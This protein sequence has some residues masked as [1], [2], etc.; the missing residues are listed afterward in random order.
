MAEVEVGGITFKGGRIILLMTVLST[1]GGGAWGAFEFYNDYR[2]MK[3]Q[4][5]SYIAPDMSGIETELAVQ[6]EMMSSIAVTV[7]A[8]GENIEK[9]EDELNK[10][11]NNVE[12]LARDTDDRTAETQ[13]ELRDDVYSLE[14]KVNERL[15]VI[16]E[17]I[18]ET[19]KDLDEKIQLILENPLNDV[20]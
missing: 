11:I 4:I 6:R 7:D 8:Q 20:E 17:D 12:E 5:Q 13:R 18:R 2:E 3:E 16:D 9:M 15:R 10:D 14:E 19:R 1:L